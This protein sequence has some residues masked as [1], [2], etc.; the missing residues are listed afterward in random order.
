MSPANETVRSIQSELESTL[1]ILDVTELEPS[2]EVSA[3]VMDLCHQ[4]LR[5]DSV[6]FS[7]WFKQFRSDAPETDEESQVRRFLKKYGQHATFAD[8][9][10]FAAA[11]LEA[12]IGE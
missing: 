6:S 1:H 7:A 2:P 9:K 4:W 11:E 5:K 12:L 10:A 3:R 8:L